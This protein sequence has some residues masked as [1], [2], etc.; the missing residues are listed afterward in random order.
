MAVKAFSVD[1]EQGIAECQRQP[2]CDYGACG[3]WHRSILSLRCLRKD[4]NATDRFPTH[5]RSVRR[6][7]TYHV[8]AIKT[9]KCCSQIA[10][11]GRPA[12]KAGREPSSGE[13]IPKELLA[14]LTVFRERCTS[15][16]F[17]LLKVF[18]LSSARGHLPILTDLIAQSLNQG[19]SAVA[20]CLLCFPQSVRSIGVSTALSI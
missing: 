8:A 12:P 1:L 4:P 14:Q 2:L 6:G 7:S 11:H 17:L 13:A 18:L 3:L 15:R 20:P 10:G 19:R 5:R 16:P 9:R